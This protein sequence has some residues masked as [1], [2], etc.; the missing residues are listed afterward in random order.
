MS[1]TGGGNDITEGQIFME[2]EEEKKKEIAWF[3]FGFISDFVVSDW[4]ERWEREKL[5]PV[6]PLLLTSFPRYTSFHPVK[7]IGYTLPQM[8][9]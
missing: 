5:F 7:F 6:V 1:F 3:Q 4:L 8:I 9:H 2:L